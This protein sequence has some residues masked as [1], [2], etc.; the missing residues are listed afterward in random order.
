MAGGSLGPNGL[1]LPTFSSDPS[2]P[3]I[4]QV[5]YNTAKGGVFVWNGTSWTEATNV[6]LDGSTEAKAAPNAT[7]LA[8]LGLSSGQ[9]WIKPE[10]A[11]QAY[12]CD[13]SIGTAANGRL[14][15]WVKVAGMSSAGYTGDAGLANMPS[16]L[17]NTSYLSNNSHFNSEGYNYKVDDEFLNTF[18]AT[19]M[20]VQSP[21]EGMTAEFN[22]SGSYVA[23]P[24]LRQYYFNVNNQQSFAGTV[25]NWVIA[26]V[27]IYW[28]SNDSNTAGVWNYPGND[29]NNH[30]G[31]STQP[32]GTNH[33]MLHGA[34]AGKNYDGFCL[35]NTCW[36]E[37]AAIW[38]S[39]DE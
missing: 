32:S 26:N 3:A 15:N 8:N 13:V 39:V 2:S 7:Y 35:D 25:D 21:A 38:L 14:A 24:D 16:T 12:Y 37:A 28:G 33:H 17:L 23:I 36:N 31:W 19:R 4:G 29:A 30:Y 9:Y 11:F 20:I 5:Y 34:Q 6:V 1:Q 27:R 10:S 18:G 22:G